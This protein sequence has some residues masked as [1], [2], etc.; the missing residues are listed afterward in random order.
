LVGP[1][2]KV[3]KFHAKRLNQSEN[4]QK[5]FGGATFL[6]HPGWPY[7]VSFSKYSEILV[8]KASFAHIGY[9]HLTCTVN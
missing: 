5:S 1:T 9:F 8:Y 2:N 4:I 3:A 7:F 6:K